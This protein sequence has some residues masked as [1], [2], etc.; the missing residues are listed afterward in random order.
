MANTVKQRYY[1]RFLWFPTASE[2]P[3]PYSLWHKMYENAMVMFEP[4]SVRHD[5]KR[6]TTLAELGEAMRPLYPYYLP[7]YVLFGHGHGE[8]GLMAL[9]NAATETKYLSPQLLV[10]TLESSRRCIVLATQCGANSFCNTLLN[11]CLL[12]RSCARFL[13]VA[14][15][16]SRLNLY[17]P[18]KEVHLQ[19]I[20]FLDGFVQSEGVAADPAVRLALLDFVREQLKNDEKIRELKAKLEKEK[21]AA[22]EKKRI[23]EASAENTRLAT[24]VKALSTRLLT[25]ENGGMLSE[26][27]NLSRCTKL[28]L[29]LS[30]LSPP[31]IVYWVMFYFACR[32]T[33]SLCDRCLK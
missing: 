28:C 25:L 6:V 29:L 26:M 4:D 17:H 2:N 20:I 1:V 11:P 9:R 33:H 3:E 7:V 13:P 14:E 8:A 22:E 31:F 19:F 15:P 5:F 32:L 21:S 10:E 12:K 16:F 23:D 27:W 18:L 24:E 30:L